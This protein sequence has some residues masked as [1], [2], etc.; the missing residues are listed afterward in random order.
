MFAYICY[1][2]HIYFYTINDLNIICSMN[3]YINLIFLYSLQS[4]TSFLKEMKVLQGCQ[5]KKIVS[6]V[7]RVVEYDKKAINFYLVMEYMFKVE[8]IFT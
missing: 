6:Y 3:I 8:Q 4:V 7:D 2:A 1:D 5:H